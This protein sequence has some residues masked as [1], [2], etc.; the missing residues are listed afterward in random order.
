MEEPDMRKVKVFKYHGAGNDFLMIDAMNTIPVLSQNEIA[1]LCHRQLGI[2]ADGLIFLCPGN[3]TDFRMK[4]HNS[5]GSL[6]EMCG[7]GARCAVAF[8]SD[9]GYIGTMSV[10]TAGDG[11]HEAEIMKKEKNETTVKISL[12]LKTEP[13][14]IEN[15][16]WYANTGVPHYVRFVE[17]VRD[18][19]VFTEGK[20]IRNDKLFSPEG[21]N[22]N[23][24]QNIDGTLYIR[25]YERGVENETLACGTGITAAALTA[26][27]A[28]GLTSPVF[29][30]AR[31][32]KLCVE[33][34]ET[35]N[36]YLTGPATFVFKTEIEQYED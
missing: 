27:K 18:I 9:S 7:N 21:I 5:D 28:L 11:K 2:G 15:G 10:F 20:S 33:K 19:D 1:R 14:Q 3:D 16:D 17:N 24:V 29:I 8:A 4:Y 25:T 22:V 36:I 13:H 32:G 31:G 26:V 23:F 12:N 30:H 6:A 35:G 34:N